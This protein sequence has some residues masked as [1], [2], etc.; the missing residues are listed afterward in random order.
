MCG[1]AGFISNKCD[2]DTLKRMGNILSHRGPDETGSYYNE[3]MGL[4]LKRLSI[5]DVVN[6]K[7]PALNEDGSV[8]AILNGEIFNYIKLRAE[9]KASG[10]QI[11]NNSDTAVLPHMYEVYGLK[12]FERLSGQF[13]IAVYDKAEKRLILARDRMGII[14]LYF[15]NKNGDFI[16][17]S[18]IKAILASG[19]VSRTLS[20][21]T[22]FDIF[23][24]W[25]PQYDRTIFQDIFSL[26]PGES[27]VL[28]NGK[29]Q[30]NKFYQL[31]YKEPN[32]EMDIDR[33]AGEIET[34]LCKAVQ[35]RLVGDVKI[36][37]YLSGGLDSSLIT[38]IV[39]SNFD[40]SVEAFSVSFEDAAFDEYKY[41]N[42]VCDH[43]GIR[44]NVIQFK[45]SEIPGLLKKI[46]WHTEAPLL[47]AGPVPLFKLSELVNRSSMKVV[48]SGEGADELFGGYDIFREVK[49]RSYLRKHPESEIRKQLFKKVNQ[50]SD[51]R[52]Q[53]A[54]AGSLNYFY[55]H[56]NED[57]LL[58]SHY[59]RW[60]QFGFFERFFSDSVKEIVKDTQYPDYYRSLNL[61]STQEI[62]TWTDIQRS[63]YFEI[64]TF[65]SQYLLSSQGDRMSMAN[66]VEVRFPFL[67][68]ELVEYCMSLEDKYKIRALNE[69]Y[70]LKKIAEK[71][72]PYELVNR[73]KF[74]YR[75]PI[76][77][78]KIIND[79]EMKYLLSEEALLRWNLFNPLKVKGF[80]N[81]VTAKAVISERESM[82]LMG[83]LTVQI[84]CDIFHLET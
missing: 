73:K 21:T 82:L 19:M 29:A 23:T 67:D 57:E 11:S 34:L 78:R 1:I 39:A 52:I 8:V 79:P 65:L 7:Q 71:Y 47:R 62:K 44:H 10:H 32:K 84:L 40:S 55:M 12:M 42:M 41:Q 31:E 20:Y 66:S 83:I 17:G 18:E 24:F 53:S 37:T 58:D 61:D 48:L 5:I 3:D 50:F 68:D 4:I 27:L 25:S 81:G 45:N 6:G 75:S 70:I 80:L 22:M 2:K 60:R 54:P 30:R 9:L 59:T 63:Q 51:A 76:D 49:I 69:K 35:K 43:L 46:I 74:P 72:L 36:S 64:K 14:P 15:Y 77:A 16:F 38:S 13:A 33:T 26:L 56:D 28:Q